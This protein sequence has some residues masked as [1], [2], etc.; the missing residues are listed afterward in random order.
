MDS[1]A[2]ELLDMI[3][4]ELIGS[5][6]TLTKL[7]T[8]SRRLRRLAEPHLYTALRIEPHRRILRKLMKTLQARPDLVRSVTKL[9]ILFEY[10]VISNH[11]LFRYP[12]DLRIPTQLFDLVETLTH[13]KAL[14]CRHQLFEDLVPLL[15]VPSSNKFEHLTNLR[16]GL[17]FKDAA[18]IEPV[19]RLPALE[20]LDIDILWIPIDKEPYMSD[21]EDAQPFV[22]TRIRQLAIRFPVSL[23]PLPIAQLSS[24]FAESMVAIET[25]HVYHPPGCGAEAF[26]HVLNEFKEHLAGPLR[27]LKLCY[28][29]KIS[30]WG[31]DRDDSTAGNRE[32]M[33]DALLSSKVEH[34]QTDLS[35]FAPEHYTLWNAI[36]L[37][38]LE[39]P[40]TLRHLNLRYIERNADELQPCAWDYRCIAQ[41]IRIRFPDLE[42]I[43]LNMWTEHCYSDLVEDL[44]NEL[45]S[46]G[47]T[48]NVQQSPYW[49]A[50]ADPGTTG[51]G[52]FDTSDT[53]EGSD[54]DNRFGGREG[55][56]I[57]SGRVPPWRR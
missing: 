46:M 37:H 29:R 20:C 15:D 47:I 44:G 1:L 2:D 57:A 10:P 21:R 43:T 22:N 51:T 9:D 23:Y 6:H 45:G 49:D 26:Q 24:A 5:G 25:L 42:C 48:Y 32:I 4:A 38:K 50:I 40:S 54:G 3:I 17:H 39:F 18:I 12:P 8:V 19:V 31:E 34:I 14:D 28:P 27:K 33:L 52:I 7:C 41:T 35:I 53:G 16:M 55:G 56:G 11:D 13:L 30:P 36:S